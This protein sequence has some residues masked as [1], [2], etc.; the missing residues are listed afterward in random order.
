VY[1]LFRDTLPAWIAS[2]LGL[3]VAI[4]YGFSA[5][6]FKDMHDFVLTLDTPDGPLHTRALTK[7]G[8]LLVVIETIDKARKQQIPEIK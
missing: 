2:I 3:G 1:L 5:R 7:K 6:R 4:L 8:Y